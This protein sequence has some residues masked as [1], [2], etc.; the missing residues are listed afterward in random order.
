M[1]TIVT[2]TY[3]T[4]TLK[5]LA[6]VE[7]ILNKGR[8]L[9]RLTIELTGERLPVQHNIYSH[10]NCSWLSPDHC[11]YHNE[12]SEY[13]EAVDKARELHRLFDEAAQAARQHLS[14][15]VYRLEDEFVIK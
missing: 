4:M 5:F 2:D 9:F 1:T 11:V 12:Y 6:T 7:P 15:P 13:G 14:I 3:P 8:L 10:S